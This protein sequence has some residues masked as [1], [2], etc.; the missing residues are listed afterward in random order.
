MAISKV[1]SKGLELKPSLTADRNFYLFPDGFLWG[2]GITDYEAFGGAE[3]DLPFRWGPRHAEHYHEDL[4][5][6]SNT[7]HHS[8]FRTAI[9]WARIEPKEGKIDKDAINFYHSYLGSIKRTGMKTFVALSDFTNP[10]WVQEQGGW[11]SKKVVSKFSQYVELVS[12]EF[13]SYIDYCLIVNDPSSVAQKSYFI[14]SSPDRGLPP[15]HNDFTEAMICLGNLTTAILEGR[16][17]F[18]KNSKTKVGFGNYYG[19]FVPLDPKNRRHQ[20]SAYLASQALNYHV[21]DATKNKVDFIGIEYYSKILM[22]EDNK[23]ARTEVYPQ[24]I[25]ESVNDYHKRYNLPLTILDN[26]Y[27]TRDD[28]E[29]IKFL[30]EHLMELHNAITQDKL[31][32]LGYN[33]WSTIHSYTWGYGFKPF[34][35]L[36]DVEGREQDV[37]GYEDL[38]GSM[39]RTI[40]KTGQF[41]GSICRE[42]G[43]LKKDYERYHAMKKPLKQ[44]LEF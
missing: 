21:P 33:W 35:A 13:G 18:H 1:H 44:W 11:L 22:A 34:F 7:L 2:S 32:V 4:D 15:Y 17:T 37:G 16:E 6:I 31:E 41:Y 8:A 42:N 19:A 9:E 24:G 30:L 28:D 20:D 36:I 23:V 29:K 27:P 10:V 14:G 38:V 12:S 5:L 26:G 3:S 25:R 39:K 40:T 43:F